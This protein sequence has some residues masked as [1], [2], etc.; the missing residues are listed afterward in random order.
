ML[1]LY[2]GG[3]KIQIHSHRGQAGMPQYFLQAEDITAV[4]KV[5]AGEGMPQCVRRATNPPDTGFLAVAP[6]HL[7]DA[8]SGE[9][10]PI[11]IE[12]EIVYSGGKRTGSL[13]VDI[14]P[15]GFLDDTTDRHIS[16]LV[17]LGFTDLDNPF[18]QVDVI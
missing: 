11:I 4:Q 8:V 3:K 5:I 14:V 18:F 16:F 7:L 2:I 1:R 6:Q 13:G 15:Y 9:G 12:Q 10:Q 17:S